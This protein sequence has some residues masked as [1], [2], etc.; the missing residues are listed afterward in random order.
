MQIR[1]KYQLSFGHDARGQQTERRTSG[2]SVSTNRMYYA[3]WQ[4]IAEFYGAG[5]LQ[6]KYVY[7][8]GIDEPIRMTS[9]QSPITDHYFHCD[10]PGSVTEI[11]D[12][13][14]NLVESYRYDVYGTPTILAPDSRLLTSSAIGNRLLF[15]GRDR[16]P[17]TG[18]YNYRY[19]YYNPVFGRF[20]QPDPIRIK[21]GDV[22]LYR[23]C[24]NNP[25]NGVDPFGLCSDR[26][27]KG[28]GWWQTTKDVL[29]ELA[30]FL[31]DSLT[32]SPIPPIATTET[33]IETGRTGSRILERNRNFYEELEAIGSPP[34]S[35]PSTTN[36]P[37]TRV[38]KASV[39]H[40]ERNYP[41]YTNS[42]S[43]GSRSW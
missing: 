10:G 29:R 2:A 32:M 30:K 27:S 31:I 5:V 42:P 41:G 34:L 36:N 7:G 43:R 8:P 1:R 9:L 17:D 12:S 18:W 15:T 39:E 13:T 16:D 38:P 11:T 26:N 33:V 25:V 21:G 40:M 3:G 19:R 6:R 24:G 23:Y 37:F 35:A 4:L 14:G 22:N 20:A 28:T